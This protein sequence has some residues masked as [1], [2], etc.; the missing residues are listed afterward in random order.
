MNGI[1]VAKIGTTDEDEYEANPQLGVQKVTLTLTADEN[2]VVVQPEGGNTN[3]IDYILI[4]S[5]DP[6][7]ISEIKDTRIAGNENV[8]DLQGRCVTN[9]QK[10][11]YIRNGKKVCY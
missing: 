6:M 8:Y 3:N 9:P 5:V 10:G 4:R 2:T 11:I 7:G 1:E